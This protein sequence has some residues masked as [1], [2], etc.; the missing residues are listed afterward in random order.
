MRCSLHQAPQLELLG[1]TQRLVMSP[2]SWPTQNAII[3]NGDAKVNVPVASSVCGSF[4]NRA[5]PHPDLWYM[6]KMGLV[7]S[8]WPAHPKAKPITKMRT[9]YRRIPC[10]EFPGEVTIIALGPLG[11]LAAALILDPEAGYPCREVVLMG[12]SD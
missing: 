4:C 7:T 3:V 8:I 10:V 9:I 2:W 11:N 1:L 5:P 6:V 12:H